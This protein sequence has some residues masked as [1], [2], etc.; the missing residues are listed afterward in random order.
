MCVRDRRSILIY[1][2]LRLFSVFRLPLLAVSGHVIII[3]I[4]IITMCS[5]RKTYYNEQRSA[6]R[7]KKK[8]KKDRKNNILLIHIHTRPCVHRMSVLFIR[9]HVLFSSKP[10]PHNFN[11][12]TRSFGMYTHNIIYCCCA[13]YRYNI[14]YSSPG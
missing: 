10:L 2:L 8:K 14:F 12:H 7:T 4:V 1:Y 13:A 11:N 6:V 9:D 5:V 3:I